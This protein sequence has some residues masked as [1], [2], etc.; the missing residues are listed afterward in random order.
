MTSASQNPV[1]GP[2]SVRDP[3]AGPAA[4]VV[5]IGFMGAGKT[6]VGALVARKA[7]RP[8][9]DLDRE[10]ERREGIPVASI[11]RERGLAAF[12]RAEAAAGRELM[13]RGRAVIAT[14]GGWAAE[15][16]NLDRLEAGAATIW[17]RVGVRTALERI[18]AADHVRPLLQ[19][20]DPRAAA[21]SLLRE[22]TPWYARAHTAIDTEGKSPRAVA[23]EVLASLEADSWKW[24]RR[25]DP[26]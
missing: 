12:R 13:A 26:K 18:A 4:P 24:N 17:L 3:A 1:A 11:I 22:R 20:S 21:E 14:G 8:F 6:T 19:V 5:L 7:D 16:G 25:R 9:Y 2:D 10:V 15:P 23:R